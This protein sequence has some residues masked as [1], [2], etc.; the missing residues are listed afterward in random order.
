MTTSE[1]VINSQEINI[2]GEYYKL[3]RPVQSTIIWQ[4]A[5]PVRA[6]EITGTAHPRLSQIRWSSSRGGIG[7][8]DHRDAV[9]VD[10]IWYGT[11]WLRVDGH[12]TLPSRV[13][14]T[15]ASGVSGVVTVDAIAELSN[16]IYAAFG[17]SVR[18]Y[19]F[20]T[21][22]WGSNLHTLAAAVTDSLTA[23][24]G[25]T[26]YMMFFY[27]SGYAYTTDGASFST[28]TTDVKYAAVWDDRLW[29]IDSTGTLRWAFNPTGTWT[30]D[31]QLPLPNDYV[32]DLFVARDAIG[33]HILYA[34]TKVGLFA[35][36]VGNAR[37]VETEMSL[38]FH[39]DAGAGVTRFRDSTY[40]PAGL[41]I[42]KYAL[43]GAGAVISTVGPDKDQGLPSDRRGK[44]VGLASSHNDLIALVTSTTAGAENL[45]LHGSS[46]MSAH[47]SPAMDTITGRSLVL[48][49]DEL[50]YQVL[51]ESEAQ[52]ETITTGLV[53]NA[54]NGYRFWFGHDRRVKY[55]SLPVDVVNPD[56][57]SDRE[58]ADSSRDDYPW[59]DGGQAEIDKLAV[60]LHIEVAGASST[61]TVT[62]YFGLNYDD[63]TWTALGEISSNGIHTYTFPNTTAGT[64][65]S[66]TGT[67]FRAFRLRV[68]LANGTNDNLSPDVRS[69]TLEYRKKLP[70]K[71]G[72]SVELN[73]NVDSHGV[74]P[75]GQR[76]NLRSAIDSNPRVEVTYRDDDG[77]TR[78]YWADIIQTTNLENTGY[79]ER[80]ISRLVLAEL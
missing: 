68:D 52:T 19:S 20:S 30:D 36:D 63:D 57:L 60:R 35:H 13:V 74:S 8:K 23:R 46:G 27:G 55:F 72:F 56:E 4:Y 69:L 75:R 1:R 77:N 80:G 33:N 40:I 65:T 15:A 3:T 5:A 53:S 71:Y 42:Y 32:Q 79:D 62:P 51:F 70:P 6:G 16:V 37:F 7:K 22:A 78:N 67:D 66:A 10:R 58:Y 45:N 17:L 12:K 9:D 38:P 61:E 54:Y 47:A 21:D 64:T 26:V 24:L 76:A 18:S 50:G 43:G 41:G 31:A 44:I 39:N 59:F 2:N 34:S 28:P 29:G 73:L 25:G 11:S 14:T 48:G 49:W